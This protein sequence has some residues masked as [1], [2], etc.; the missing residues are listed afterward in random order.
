MS[1]IKRIFYGN[2]DIDKEKESLFL[3][4]NAGVVFE[5]NGECWCNLHPIVRDYLDDMTQEHRD[6]LLGG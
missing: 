5:Y 1:S 4:Y 3:L 6:S 2:Y